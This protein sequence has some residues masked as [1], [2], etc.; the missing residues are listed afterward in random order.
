MS[1]LAAAHPSAVRSQKPLLGLTSIIC[2]LG[3]HD[4]RQTDT[5][6]CF[7]SCG[8]KRVWYLRPGG[9]GPVGPA[10]AGPTFE[11]GRTFFNL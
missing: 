4:V 6:P 11:L 3:H 5:L 10:M 9:T 8:L 1:A 7:K 2:I